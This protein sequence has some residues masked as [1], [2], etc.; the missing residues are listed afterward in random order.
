MRYVRA[1]GDEERAELTRMTR[2]AVGRVSQR[3]QMILLSSERRTVPQIAALF[4]TSLTTVRFWIG[5]FET[6]GP[7]GLY[8]AP[9]S[10]RPQTVTAT[11]EHAL[12]RLICQDPQQAGYVATF[13]TVAMLVGALAPLGLTVSAGAVRAAL[14]RLELR[15]GRP[16][17]AMPRKVDPQKAQKQWAIALAV[18]SAGPETT[19]LYADES[20][21]QLLPL[22]RARWHWV[23]QQVRIPTPGTNETRT[24]F[25]ALNYGT[26]RWDYL[27]RAHN[28]NEDFVA[29]LE[30]LLRC[31]AQGPILLIVDNSSS[32]TAGL[33]TQWLAEPA[34]ARL[35]LHY[36]PTYCSH[37]NPVELIWLRLKNA[38]AANRLHGSMQRLVDSVATFFDEMPPDQALEWAAA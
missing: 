5:R 16:R 15:W 25:G 32:H 20:R 37:L 29:F 13:W 38:V 7:S 3:A 28:R 31:Y 35:Q 26:G 24:L 8:D 22:L 4:A 30:H 11:G 10:G 27:V 36:L 12:H 17:L 18:V 9:R 33:V 6:S 14:H 21:I 2:Q 34:H 19:I 23:G 1:L